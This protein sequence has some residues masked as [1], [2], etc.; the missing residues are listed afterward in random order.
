[1]ATPHA[2]EELIFQRALKLD[3]DERSAEAVKLLAP[4]MARLDNPRHLF[5]YAQCL[6]RAGVDWKEVVSCLRAMVQY[7]M[8]PSSGCASMQ[9]DVSVESGSPAAPACFQ[10]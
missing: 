3:A 2:D 1:M 4:L 10:R 8:K 7:L 6:I 5:A 9:F